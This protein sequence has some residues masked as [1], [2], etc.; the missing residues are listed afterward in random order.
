MKNCLCYSVQIDGSTDKQQVDSKFIT[1][2]YAPFNKVSV[3]TVFLGIASSKLGGAECFLD[4]FKSCVERAAVQTDN[5][6]QITT[7]GESANSAKILACG[8]FCRAILAEIFSQYGVCVCRRSDLALEAVQSEVPERSVWMS[9]V[10]AVSIFFRTSP[11]RTK[12]LHKVFNTECITTESVTRIDNRS[13]I[14][15]F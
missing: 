10:L 8:G 7:D 3:N 12:L 6:V 2:R 15:F 4:F 14:K 13:H 1:A 5:L 9:N 11:R